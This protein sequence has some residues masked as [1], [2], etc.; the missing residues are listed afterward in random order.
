MNFFKEHFIKF[1]ILAVFWTGRHLDSPLFGPS[2]LAG[3]RSK[4]RPVLM[5][6]H[7]RFYGRPYSC[8]S[9]IKL[10]LNN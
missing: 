1:F 6:V 3:G 5:A 4:K 7:D 9:Y 8:H 2:I 10:N